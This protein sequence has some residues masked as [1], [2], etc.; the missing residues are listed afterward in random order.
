MAGFVPVKTTYFPLKGGLDLTSPWLEKSAGR[1]IAAQNYEAGTAGGYRAIQ[2]YQ[3]YD[4]TVSPATPAAVPGSGP[5]RGVHVLSGDVYAWR[6]NAGATAC[7]MWKATAAGWVQQDLGSYISFDTGTAEIAEGQTVTGAT[8][9]A[10]ATVRRVV[11]TGGS[12]GG[13]PSAS[14]RLTL[15]GITSGPFQ[16]GENLQVGGVTKAVA[17]SADVANALSAGGRYQGV[18]ANFYGTGYPSAYL[19]NGA[20]KAFEWTGSYFTPIFT[21]LATD[22]P[23]HIIAHSDH[24]F[25]GYAQGSVQHS[26]LGEPLV[27]EATTGAGEIAVGDEVVGL[28]PMPGNV[29]CIR[30]RNSINLLYGNN[31]TDWQRKNWSQTIGGE[32]YTGQN[33]GDTFFID[34]NSIVALAATQNFGDFQSGSASTAI[35]PWLNIYAPYAYASSVSRQKQQYR[36]FFAGGDGAFADGVGVYMTVSQGRVVGLMPVKFLDPVREI[37]TGED[38]TGAEISFFGSD[39]GKVFQL[40]VGTTFDGEPLVGFLRL[41]FHHFKN[42]AYRKRF[43][44]ANFDMDAENTVHLILSADA[45]YGDPNIASHALR[46]FDQVG[47]GGLWDSSNWNEFYWDVKLVG[48]P[49]MDLA[50]TGRNLSLLVYSPGTSAGIHALNGVVV[51]YSDRR[52]VR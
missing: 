23:R 3:L 7:D 8:S 47:V 10:S 50:I 45:D 4:G 20:D 48:E 1:L 24:L 51:H 11:V 32:P 37:C 39:D 43:R 40:D 34:S 9:G 21:G 6:D 28:H 13:S 19:C 33:L 52:L 17:T 15:Y 35:E 29:L 18:N 41:T 27:F 16:S 38:D 26:S 2:G 49:A 31:S 46:Y 12:W 5:I 30:S 14:G 44:Q 42:P 22:N 36:V 25:L